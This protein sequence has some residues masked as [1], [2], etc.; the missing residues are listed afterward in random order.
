[1]KKML[2]KMG[3]SHPVYLDTRNPHC[4]ISISSKTI[5]EDIVL[6]QYGDLDALCQESTSCYNEECHHYWWYNQQ[7][8]KCGCTETF[9]CGQYCYEYFYTSGCECP[10]DSYQQLTSRSTFMCIPEGYDECVNGV[11]EKTG[12]FPE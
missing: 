8:H 7:V 6:P 10:P 2:R 11:P 1:M 3:S 4:Y 5:C 9:F 12:P